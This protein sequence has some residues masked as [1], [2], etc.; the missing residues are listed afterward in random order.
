MFD[1]FLI[2]LLLLHRFLMNFVKRL[3]TIYL[4]NNPGL[5]SRNLTFLWRRFLSYRNQ[6]TDLQSKSVDW[7]LNDKDV[8]NERVNC[9]VIDALHISCSYPIFMQFVIFV[10]FVWIQKFTRNILEILICNPNVVK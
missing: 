3:L 7:F 8:S 10:C 9:V 5:L 6:S 4:L 1:S 2:T